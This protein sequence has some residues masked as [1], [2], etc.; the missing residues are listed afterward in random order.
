[1]YLTCAQRDVEASLAS[2]KIR[3]GFGGGFLII[4]NFEADFSRETVR[5]CLG[6]NPLKNRAD[7]A[8]SF[9]Q[10]RIEIFD[11]RKAQTKCQPLRRFR[12]L[13]DSVCLLFG[14]DL[15]TML[16]R[17]EKPIFLVRGYHFTPRQQVQFT[18]SSQGSEHTGFLQEWMLRAVDKLK[19]LH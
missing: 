13:R 4:E 3:E 19:C 10:G 11:R 14:L 1:E 2:R 5:G 12:F 6:D 9:L 7:S 8:H 17:A 16:D 15:Q 18:K